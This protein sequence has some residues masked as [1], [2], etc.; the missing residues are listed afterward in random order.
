[1]Y[2]ENIMSRIHKLENIYKEQL[3]NKN[4]ENISIF[5][6]YILDADITKGK[7]ARFLI[8][9]FL[10]DKFLE[11]DLIGGLESTIGQSISLFHKCKYK[12]PIEKRSIYALNPETKLPLYQSPGDLWNSVKQ[13]QDELSGKELK[14]E[15]QEQVYRE[16]EFVYKDEETGFQIVSPLTEESA[17]WWGK[18]TRWC[19]SAENNNMF[20][21]YAKDSPLFILLMPNG[22]KLQVWKHNNNIQFMDELD[23]KITLNYI[24]QHWSLLE[25]ICKWLN[26][27]RF[28]NHNFIIDFFKNNKDLLNNYNNYFLVN[29]CNKTFELYNLFLKQDKKALLIFPDHNEKEIINMIKDGIINF[30]YNLPDNITNLKNCLIILEHRKQEVKK[31]IFNN[32]FITLLLHISNNHK[33]PI[34]DFMTKNDFQDI[35][36]LN[37]TIFVSYQDF[38]SEDDFKI[39]MKNC[40]QYYSYGLFRERLNDKFK[41]QNLMNYIYHLN[42]KNIQ[43]IPLEFI[44]EKMVQDIINDDMSLLRYIPEHY[45]TEDIICKG[46]KYDHYLL[47][48]IS[49]DLQTIKVALEA[50]NYNDADFYVRDDLKEYIYENNLLNTKKS[51]INIEEIINNFNPKKI[52]QQHDMDLL[53]QIPC[54]LWDIELLK[55]FILEIY[56]N[57]DYILN[58]MKNEKLCNILNSKQNEIIPLLN[59]LMKQEKIST[60]EEKIAIMPQN[61]LFFNMFQNALFNKKENHYKKNKTI[62][63]ILKNNVINSLVMHPKLRSI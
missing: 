18:G 7:Y 25:P 37:K 49:K 12:L 32:D 45:L 51:Y 58:V 50:F 30:S 28:T 44:T 11:E 13:Y 5:I 26:D 1:M 60:L 24:E 22:D 4:V 33:K 3:K 48:F 8:E 20:W 61:F 31:G 14:R 43:M 55:Y 40:S 46:L 29:D 38:F 41:N 47:K 9:A 59:I 56:Y 23:N 63:E 19:T 39:Y 57:N 10:N 34:S 52:I 15:E 27:I 17:K 42:R 16:T 21:N 6:Q 35:F 53:S 36:K 62:I 2:K 54:H